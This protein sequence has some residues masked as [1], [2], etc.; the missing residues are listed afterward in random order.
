MDPELPLTAQQDQ[1][2]P[3]GSPEVK[4]TLPGA[5]PLVGCWAGCYTPARRPGNSS[6]VRQTAPLCK[7][8]ETFSQSMET[9]PKLKGEPEP[10]QDL[11]GKTDSD[12]ADQTKKVNI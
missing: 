4:P 1:E 5:R 6:E 3:S 11:G 2:D 8:G 7:D 12:D 10:S 9:A